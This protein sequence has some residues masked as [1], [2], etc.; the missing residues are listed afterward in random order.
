MLHQ[1]VHSCNSPNVKDRQK[2]VQY[3][4][5][6]CKS[7]DD[8]KAI[9]TVIEKMPDLKAWCKTLIRPKYSTKKRHK[10]GKRR[11]K[12]SCLSHNESRRPNPR[13]WMF[14]FMEGQS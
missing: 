7:I 11:M 13:D 8:S 5:D 3:L 9:Y 2:I 4:I 12:R 14:Q 6:N 1:Q 10:Q